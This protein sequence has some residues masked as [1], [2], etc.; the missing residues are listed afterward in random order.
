M[1]NRLIFIFAVIFIFVFIVSPFSVFAFV[2]SG[3]GEALL[4]QEGEYDIIESEQSGYKSALRSSQSAEDFVYNALL[5]CEDEIDVSL[6]NIPLDDLLAFYSNV[7]NDN[8]DLFYVSSSVSYTYYRTTGYI[9]QIFPEY[10]LSADEITQAKEVFNNGAAKALSAIDA[11]MND[12]QIA[13]TL[14]DIVCSIAHYPNVN[15]NTDDKEIYHS[16]YGL[17]Y[18]GE[19]VCAGYTLSYSY[20]MNQAGVPCEYVVSNS[21]EHA[22]NLVKIGN[23]W[24]NV[25]CTWDDL[26]FSA[27]ISIDGCMSHNHFLKSNTKFSSQE[28][29][30]HYDGV[31]YDSIS[32]V[33]TSFDSAFWDNVI[34]NIY[35]VNG[36]YYYLVFENGTGY[37]NLKKKTQA[38]TVFNV[39][40]I[41]SGV[42]SSFSVTVYDQN[43]NAY[44]NTIPDL[45]SRIKLLDNR[46]YIIAGKKI[47]SVNTAGVQY[48]IT[49]IDDFCLGIGC[50]TNNNLT[51]QYSSDTDTVNVLDKLEYFNEYMTVTKNVNYNNYPDVN[52]DLTVNAKDYAMI[53]H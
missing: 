6:Y 47:Y 12:L 45:F 17:F 13:L 21:M 48:L 44:T 26:D 35:S 39:K 53:T 52:Y 3:E 27:S 42:S 18:D 16:A 10:S 14:H 5:E 25:D 24:Y 15:L 50:D 22:W 19:V 51:Y 49:G 31:T 41:F 43:G 38:G 8:P 23:S 29:S 20:L 40:R 2:S 11:N 7:V 9:A 46:F 36:D 28:C 1:K 37:L 4:L 33:D 32:A 30:F 34:S